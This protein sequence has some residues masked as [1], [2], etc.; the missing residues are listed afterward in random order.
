[1]KTA[2][3]DCGLIICDPNDNYR[4]YILLVEYDRVVMY[5]FDEFCEHRQPRGI[6]IRS[7]MGPD[8]RVGV[9]IPHLDRLE[10]FVK[11]VLRQPGNEHQIDDQQTQQEWLNQH[12]E[13]AKRVTGSP[14]S[15]SASSSSSPVVPEL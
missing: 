10:N 6:A 7:L 12:M 13:N 11:D 15:S 14:S 9:K 4:A 3:D 8:P 1:M 2:W 5:R